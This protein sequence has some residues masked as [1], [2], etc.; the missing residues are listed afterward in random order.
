VYNVFAEIFLNILRFIALYIIFGRL[1]RPKGKW[2]KLA[3][4][5][6]MLFGYLIL[7][8]SWWI[9]GNNTANIIGILL[10]L[11]LGLLCRRDG[12]R[13]LPII[14]AFYVSAVFVMIALIVNFYAFM[15]FDTSVFLDMFNSYV[16]DFIITILYIFWAVFYYFVSRK[17][18]ASVPLSFSLLITLMPFGAVGIGLV[19]I[20]N[21]NQLLQ[22]ESGRIVAMESGL[23]LY[24][25]L[26]CTLILI[27]NM[28]AYYLYV[29]FSVVHESMR[30]AQELNST[31]P[32]WTAENGLSPLFI[33]K[34]Q[35]TPRE[36]QVIEILLFGKT[37]KEIA[38]ELDLAV[39]TVQTHLKRVYKKTNAAGRFALASL[40]RGE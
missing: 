12:D 36:Q 2:K 29:R 20:N 13:M 32:I 18:T 38:M 1:H 31:P 6:L 16:V 19:A 37:D 33:E 24:G 25:G 40:V 21:M 15:L 23:F 4:Y 9:I 22:D 30:F 27:F 17:M 7:D 8:A 11:L 5:A 26:F 39:N 10:L 3:A 14:S 35:I 28:C 34:Y